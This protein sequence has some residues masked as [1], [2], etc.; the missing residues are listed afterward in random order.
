MLQLLQEWSALDYTPEIV[1]ESKRT[2]DGR[3][4]LSGVLQKADTLNQNGRVYPRALLE[5]E[6]RNYQKFIKE[7]RAIGELDH[8]R[9]SV[10][11]LKNGSHVITEAYLD[12][13]VV[14]GTLEVLEKLP[15][16]KILAGYIEH[17][18]RVGI[19]SRGVGST[20]NESGRQVVNDD[21][22]LIC[23]DMVAEPSTAGAFMMQEGRVIYDNRGKV[24]GNPDPQ[25]VSAVIRRHDRIRAL[26][27]DILRAE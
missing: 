5:R 26:V 13:D 14:Y 18:I 4:F 7:R 11:E 23:W 6:V 10:V 9:E 12:G 2:R 3:I 27:N 20:Q 21:F 25:D 22:Q 19:S 15:M 8:P 1:Q 17:D 24:L 16:G